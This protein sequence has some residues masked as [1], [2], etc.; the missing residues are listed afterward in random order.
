MRDA[1]ALLCLLFALRLHAAEPEPRGLEVTLNGLDTELTGAVRSHLTLSQ[2]EKREASEAQVRRLLARSDQEIREALE[3]YGYYEVQVDKRLDHAADHLNAVFDIRSGPP[4]LVTHREVA[5]AGPAAQVPAVKKALDT[6]KPAVGERFDHGAYERSKAALQSAL[7]D[8]GFLG[9]QLLTHRVEVSTATRAAD[10]ILDWDGGTRYSFGPVTF[11]ASQFPREFLQ[12]FLPFA[13]GDAYSGDKLRELQ[14]RLINGDYFATA[15]VQPHLERA[16][17][18]AVPIEVELTPAKR[19]VYSGSFYFSTD[20]GA[21]VEL[22]YQ[23]RWLN[24]KGHKLQTDINEAQRL[25][26]ADIRYLIPLPGADKRLLSFGGT[27]RDEVTDSSESRTNKIVANESRLWHGFTRTLGLQYL[28]GDFEIGTTRGNSQLLFAEGTLQR[29][30]TDDPAFARRGYSLLLALR[31]APSDAVSDT[32]FA[33]ITTR[34]KWLR[35]FGKNSRLIVRGALGAMQVDDFDVLPPD[36]RYFSGGDRTVRGF[37]YEEIGTRDAA[38][39]VIGGQY[40]AELSTEYEQYVHGNWGAAV[41][42]DA[43]DAFLGSNFETNVG[44]GIGVRW[45]SPVGPVRLD[46]AYPIVT[47]LNKEWRLHLTIGPDL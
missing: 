28:A 31:V 12:R 34:A 24:D 21:G 19:N 20:T 18:R 40:L 6:F 8:S 47:Q 22:G 35:A 33:S 14:Q 7:V 25:Q 3:A 45:K 41:F 23:R 44:A 30:S 38:G 27:Y 4:V 13:P 46:V 15:T 26:S 37:A 17:A 42:V 43:G 11:S 16:V 39:N 5:V 36:L 1:R 29:S 10:I 32:R 2:Y 9:A